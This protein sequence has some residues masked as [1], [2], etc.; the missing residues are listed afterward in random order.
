MAARPESKKNVVGGGCRCLV[1]RIR[2]PGKAIVILFLLSG[3]QRGEGRT[4]QLLNSALMFHY[5]A[6]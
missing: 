4:T 2:Y 6:L 1:W 3:L 5:E